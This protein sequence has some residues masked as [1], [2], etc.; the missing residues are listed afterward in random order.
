MMRS[1]LRAAARGDGRSYPNPSVGAVVFR[2]D[3]ILGRGTTR[4]QPAGAHAEIVAMEAARRRF[5]A[6]A[7]RRASLAVTLEPCNFVGRTGACTEAILEAGIQR[8]VVGCRDPHSR[9]SGRGISRLRRRGVDVSSGV[10]EDECRYQH[11]G[12]ISVCELGR[13]HVTLKMATSLDGRIALASGE[14][15][16]ITSA[17]SREFVHRLRDR[18][19]AVMVGSETARADDPR[20]DV[21]RQGRVMRVPIRILLDG[22]LRVPLGARLYDCHEGAPTWVVCREAARGIR[23]AREAASRLL[24]FPPGE[25]GFL[26]L[27]AVF[28]RLAREGL[29]T[30]LVEGGGR[31][32]AALLRADLVDE[33]HWMLAPKLIGGEGRRALGPLGLERLADAISLETMRVTRR[34]DDLHVQGLIARPVQTAKTAKKKLKKK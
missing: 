19:D 25:G 3:Q 32:A 31:L 33:V 30:V 14:S 28:R 17:A 6:A 22:R 13:P 4:P 18:N 10:L 9:V 11:R 23:R 26:D 24:T 7:L 20:L 16:W 27:D 2:G 34:G 12:F 1:A 5:G 21:R 8:V 15:R 29:T